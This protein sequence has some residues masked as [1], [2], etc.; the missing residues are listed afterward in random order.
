MSD[1]RGKAEARVRVLEDE[2]YKLRTFIDVLDS[3]SND[4]KIVR[5]VVDSSPSSIITKSAESAADV[6]RRTSRKLTITD[7][8]VLV[9][10]ESAAPVD[11][12][13]MV[14]LILQKGVQI[15]S[16]NPRVSV[17]SSLSRDERFENVRGKGWILAKGDTPEVGASDASD[18]TSA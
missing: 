13:S 6:V 8:A 3:F 18:S 14:D 1:L 5:S 11:T 10:Q 17:G 12:D 16:A 2:L 15:S 4:A 9:L 7:A